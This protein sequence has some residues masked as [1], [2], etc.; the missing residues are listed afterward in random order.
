MGKRAA[1]RGKCRVMNKTRFVSYEEVSELIMTAYDIAKAHGLRA[2]PQDIR[3]CEACGDFHLFYAGGGQ[4]P[5]IF[6][7]KPAS[8]N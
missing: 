2:I 8:M 5:S 4:P 6:P 3:K 7:P 1:N